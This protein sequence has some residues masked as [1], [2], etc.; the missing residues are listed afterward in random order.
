MLSESTNPT[1]TNVDIILID[2]KKNGNGKTILSQ[3]RPPRRGW[4][5]GC[6]DWPGQGGGDGGHG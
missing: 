6:S 1:V 3:P 5:V 4:V 2:G